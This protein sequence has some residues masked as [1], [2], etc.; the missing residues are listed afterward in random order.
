[1]RP[2]TSCGTRSERHSSARS[3]GSC[4]PTRLPPSSAQGRGRRTASR[5]RREPAARRQGA[6]VE[7][8]R[9]PPD[10]HARRDRERVSAPYRRRPGKGR[11]RPRPAR[12]DAD[13]A[14]A[15]AD[16]APGASPDGAGRALGWRDRAARTDLH[17]AFGAHGGAEDVVR[18]RGRRAQ[19]EPGPARKAALKGMKV[20][21]LGILVR[22]RYRQR[23]GEAMA[24]LKDV[25]RLADDLESLVGELRSELTNGTDFERLVQIADEISEHA[26]NVAQTFTSV[27]DA[28]MER[29]DEVS[30]GNK[31]SSSG[32]QSRKRSQT[33]SSSASS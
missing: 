22:R 32:S 33:A 9:R 18:A 13:R 30:S 8:R 23:K 20:R 29:I 4:P 16:G 28:L 3:Q 24:S 6:R 14:P 12:P 2:P 7:R 21:Q 19:P 10:A 15:R 11:A 5:R 27:N 17:A 31:K 25:E 26:D 1:M